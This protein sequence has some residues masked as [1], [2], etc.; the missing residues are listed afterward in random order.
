MTG[1]VENGSGGS[2]QGGEGLGGVFARLG[3]AAWLGV[4]WAVLPAAGG[5]ILLANMKP[6]SEWLDTLG[7]A[8][9]LVYAAIFAVSA[10]FAFLPTYAQATLGG[11][12]FGPVIGTGAA[13]CG[14]VGAAL[15]G[16]V[17]ARQI[18][19][20]R[21]EQEIKRH[22]QA[23]TVRDALVNSGAGKR[24][25]I[26]TLLRVPPNSPFALTNLVLSTTGVPILTY[27]LA[28]AVGMLPRTAAAAVIGHQITDISNPERPKWL[29]FGGIA[30]TVVVVIIIG[31]IASKALKKAAAAGTATDGE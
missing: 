7:P 13:L 22:K 18:S 23:E 24:F 8:A 19:A 26:V 4:V 16:R 21:V 28:T 29:V 10:G 20:D 27:V 6:V 3:P 14:F 17:L 5:F 30:L 9:A 2:A 12:A 15:I 25:W 1:D 11:Y 31:Q